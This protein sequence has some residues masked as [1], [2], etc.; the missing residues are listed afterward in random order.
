MPKT[1]FSPKFGIGFKGNKKENNKYYK[2]SAKKTGISIP[3][4]KK[5]NDILD[6]RL[7]DSEVNLHKDQMEI[8][9]SIQPSKEYI[10]RVK[11]NTLGFNN[12]A[13]YERYKADK[14]NYQGDYDGNESYYKMRNAKAKKSIDKTA[15]FHHSGLRGRM[16]KKDIFKPIMAVKEGVVTYKFNTKF[17]N[18]EHMLSLVPAQ[19]KLN[20]GRFNM[21]DNNNNEYLVECNISSKL[22]Y[23]DL[24]VVKYNNNVKLNEDVNRIKS[25]FSY[26]S[27]AI[28][29]CNGNKAKDD[30]NKNVSNAKK[31]LK[32]DDWYI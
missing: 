3:N 30:I 11:Y 22:K 12:K 14:D 13:E 20:E 21:V 29:G 18:E 8:E 2:D 32:Y 17:I 15:D 6:F 1:E 24:K 5:L 23:T 9:Y 16:Y 31:M 19:A 28:Y 4:V 25:L 10:E 26:D 7:S 27:K